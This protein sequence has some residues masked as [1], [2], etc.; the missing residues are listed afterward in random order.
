MNPD[1]YEKMHEAEGRMW[2]YRALH[3]NLL[4]AA[5]GAVGGR[6]SGLLLDAGCGTGGVLAGLRAAF[7][8]WDLIGLD[9]EEIAASLARQKSGAAVCGG[10]LN[11][12]PFKTEALDIIV[13]A[14]VLCHRSV[15]EARALQEF[16]RCL[17]PGGTLILNLPAF[18]WM[19]S[20]HDRAV[21]TI[22]RYEAGDIA[23]RL[24]AAGFRTVSALYWNS[25]LFPLM[26][27]RRKLFSREGAVSDV[28]EYPSGI[29][30][31]F[32]FVTKCETM[33]FRWGLRFP[34]GG[35]VLVIAMK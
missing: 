31:F 24:R 28:M 20:A 1:E 11:Q 25:L 27:I 26:V 18:R 14:D 16:W 21:H 12:L 8:D 2:W 23:H 13:S 32:R 3:R 9:F 4:I 10:S 22:R 29:E 5:D 17:S 7:P 19:M 35:S 6:K 34:Y 30:L 15:D 33:L